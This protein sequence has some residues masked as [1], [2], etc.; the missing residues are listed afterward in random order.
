MLYGYSF[1]RLKIPGMDIAKSYQ[2]QSVLFKS[3]IDGRRL[4]AGRVYE[5]TIGNWLSPV[6]FYVVFHG[7]E[8]TL[9]DLQRDL[10]KFYADSVALADPSTVGVGAPCCVKVRKKWLRAKVLWSCGSKGDE[11]HVRL[12]DSGEPRYVP[13][14]EVRLLS[15]EFASLPPLAVECEMLGINKNCL[16]GSILNQFTRRCRRRCAFMLSFLPGFE[17]KLFVRLFDGRMNDLFFVYFGGVIARAE[18]AERQRAA[19]HAKKGRGKALKGKKEQSTSKGPVILCDIDDL[20]P[21]DM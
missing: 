11:F 4:K 12:V 6:E 20:L 5:V 1:S 14:E 18:Q 3:G 8:K 10:N 15:T 17:K 19:A 2:S 13:K 7:F 9:E 16:T 21:E